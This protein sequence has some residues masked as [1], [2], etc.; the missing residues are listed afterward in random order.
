MENTE[1]IVILVILVLTILVMAGILVLMLRIGTIL[2]QITVMHQKRRAGRTESGQDLKLF[3]QLPIEYRDSV[4]HIIAEVFGDISPEMNDA[5]RVWQAEIF[6]AGTLPE[7]GKP[8]P[9]LLEIE[10]LS[11]R[12]GWEERER[13]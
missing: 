12:G 7:D 8:D 5:F 2:K 1:A 4:N 3:G 10:A 13:L 6:D 11:F 9:K